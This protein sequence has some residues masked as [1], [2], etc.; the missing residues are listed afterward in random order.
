MERWVEFLSND[1]ILRVGIL[2]MNPCKFGIG[3]HHL[4]IVVDGVYANPFDDLFGLLLYCDY[5]LVKSFNFAVVLLGAENV[6]L[7]IPSELS[8]SYHSLH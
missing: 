2:K 6:N 4:L 3:I 5:L 7:L 1:T 8:Q